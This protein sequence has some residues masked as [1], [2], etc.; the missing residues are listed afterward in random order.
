MEDIIT[1]C[2]NMSAMRELLKSLHE[3]HSAAAGKV[4]SAKNS[5]PLTKDTMSEPDSTDSGDLPTVKL[6]TG[7]KDD[8]LFLCIVSNVLLQR[9]NAQS[10][11][12][13]I[14]HPLNKRVSHITVNFSNI[15]ETSRI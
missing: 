7:R 14:L 5:R 4:V 12:P 8:S 9:A 3:L 10:I 6:D 15:W 11:I 2:L 13:L 1:D